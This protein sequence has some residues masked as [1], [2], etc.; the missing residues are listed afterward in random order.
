M[1]VEFVNAY[2]H[3]NCLYVRLIIIT[4]Q[5]ATDSNIYGIVKMLIM[6]ADWR[7]QLLKIVPSFKKKESLSS[8]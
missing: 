7:F 2:S 3:P 5:S 6:V 1:L 4:T 8:I